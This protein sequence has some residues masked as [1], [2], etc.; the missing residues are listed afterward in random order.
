MT[1]SSGSSFFLSFPPPNSLSSSS[2]LFYAFCSSFSLLPLH[3]IS[4]SV[5]C[6]LFIGLFLRAA[7]DRWS[8]GIPGKKRIK[9][10]SLHPYL[11]L[12]LRLKFLN[13]KNEARKSIGFLFQIWRGE[14][15]LSPGGQKLESLI[16]S[17][18]SQPAFYAACISSSRMESNPM[19][20]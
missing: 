8:W 4:S 9:F 12:L 16:N 15:S 11:L 20:R 2:I 17:W 1:P 10:V 18:S 13:L 5:L 6:V 19:M 7:T 14:C 3:P